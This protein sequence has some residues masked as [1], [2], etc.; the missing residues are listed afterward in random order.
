MAGP[1]QPADRWGDR[2]RLVDQVRVALLKLYA[3]AGRAPTQSA[4]A[5]RARLSETTVQ[6]QIEELHRRDL[7]VL[8][9]DRIVGAYPFT[10]R[11]A[12]HQVTL[13]GRVVNAMCAVDA[14]GIGAM[15]GRDI[16]IA[17]RCRHCGA[18]IRIATRDQGRALAQ[19]E[20]RTA[21]MWQSV[22]YEGACA[23]N[24]LCAT[25]AFFCS[26]DHL[27]AWRREQ[28]AD[29]AGFRLSVEEGLEA[30]RALFGPSLAGLDTAALSS[31]GS[32]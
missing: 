13:D 24:S 1:N 27:S 19:I 17:S 31:V 14:L 3:E 28:A 21:V 29:E 6:A 12:D 25:T 5:K 26:D 32:T 23:A 11:D 15:T 10:D 16:A 2:D 8:N 22:R 18:Q 30:G 9:G 7:V 4:I 20:P